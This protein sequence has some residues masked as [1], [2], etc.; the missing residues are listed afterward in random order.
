M[1]DFSNGPLIT[2]EWIVIL[3]IFC[4][5]ISGRC[6]DLVPERGIAVSVRNTVRWLYG[7]GEHTRVGSEGHAGCEHHLLTV[8]MK[9]TV[10]RAPRCR[11]GKGNIYLFLGFPAYERETGGVG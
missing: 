7:D 2:P 4:I 11:Q 10:V 9:G 8:T 6:E 1:I 3:S 5:G